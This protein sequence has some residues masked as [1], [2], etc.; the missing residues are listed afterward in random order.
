MN[1]VIM[2]DNG[3]VGLVVKSRRH[4]L[5]V[6]RVSVEDYDRV[7]GKRWYVADTGARTLYAMTRKAPGQDSYMHRVLTNSPPK[8]MHVDHE[9][10]NGLNNSRPNLSVI[11][12]GENIWR[13]RNGKRLRY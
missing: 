2:L 6:I 5:K 13:N 9:D 7:K 4:G 1:D 3:C 10:E 11:T 8:G 12:H